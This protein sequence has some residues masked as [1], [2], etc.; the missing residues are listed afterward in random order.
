MLDPDMPASALRLMGG[1]M[2]AQEIRTARAFIRAANEAAKRELEDAL[3]EAN[4]LAQK[5]G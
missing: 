3:D 4:R 2:T 1:E 5:E